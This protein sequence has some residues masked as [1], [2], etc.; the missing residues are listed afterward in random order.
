MKFTKEN[1]IKKIETLT[2]QIESLKNI[3]RFSSEFEK[4]QRDTEIA[5]EYIFGQDSRHV[6]DFNDIN[7]SMSVWTNTTPDSVFQDR[8]TKGLETAEAIL[9]SMVNEIQEYWE[10]DGSTPSQG[11]DITATARSNEVF[12]IHGHDSGAK[13]TMARFLTQLGLEPIILHEQPNKG[14]TIIEKFEDHA[15]VSFAVALLTPDDVGASV[16]EKNSLKE[17]ARQNV[18]FEFGYFIGKLGRE[19]V[20]GFVK[21]NLEVPSD[22]AG[23]LY[24]PFD[25]VGKW[26]FELVKEL[27]SAGYDVDANKAL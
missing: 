12:I 9:S 15:N 19:N 13:E 23:V 21:D 4:W 27:K 10:E 18:I 24:I 14:R 6:K 17:R 26:K 2:S 20:V 25:D 1:A 5:L 7:Y 11:N 8:Y 22:Y 3:K 16:K